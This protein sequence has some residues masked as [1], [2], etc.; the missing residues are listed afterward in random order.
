MS[1]TLT[2]AV[3]DKP[4]AFLAVR[5]TTNLDQEVSHP[6]EVNR[7]EVRLFDVEPFKQVGDAVEVDH[8]YGDGAR[9]LAHLALSASLTQR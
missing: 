9:H 3:N 7:Y 1:L 2:V 5:R 6:L 4:V 8:T